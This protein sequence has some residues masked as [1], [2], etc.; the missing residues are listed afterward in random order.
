MA[1]SGGLVTGTNTKSESKNKK[2]REP[3]VCTKRL[4]RILKE[5]VAGTTGD[6]IEGKKLCGIFDVC[7]V[8]RIGFLS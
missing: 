5:G 7:S 2:K 6:T 1:A 4:K 8:E 3:H